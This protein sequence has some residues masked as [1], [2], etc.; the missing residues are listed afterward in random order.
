M[1]PA[2][3]CVSDRQWSS[4]QIGVLGQD[5]EDQHLQLSRQVV[6]AVQ[7]RLIDPALQPDQHL[8]PAQVLA[9]D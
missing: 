7:I 4:Q 9:L 5:C 3:L 1:F 2:S 8:P 6:F